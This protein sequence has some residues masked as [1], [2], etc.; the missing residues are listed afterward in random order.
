M[1]KLRPNQA[2]Q[3]ATDGSEVWRMVANT[4]KRLTRALSPAVADLVSR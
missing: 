3:R 2:M 1:G 4:F